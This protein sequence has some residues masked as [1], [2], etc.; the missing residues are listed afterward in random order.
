MLRVLAMNE[1]L[2]HFFLNEQ[3]AGRQ[4]IST[5]ANEQAIREIYLRPFEI[6]VK[7]GKTTAMM[8]AFNR[9]GTTWAGAHRGLLTEVLRNEWGFRGCVV[10]DYAEKPYQDGAQGIRAGNDL[11]L[12]GLSPAAS[13]KA[14]RK[15]NPNTANYYLRQAAKNVCYAVGNSEIAMN[16]LS[17]K[18][19]F[20]EEISGSDIALNVINIVGGAF[21]GLLALYIL[22]WYIRKRQKKA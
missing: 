20:S 15:A 2:K 21:F 7:E 5:Y 12:A 22:I 3:E 1:H 16:G 14:D 11:W 19:T 13:I 18:I 17:S 6:T 4:G 9:I 8:S 10:T